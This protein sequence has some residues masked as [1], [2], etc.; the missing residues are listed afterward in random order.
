MESRRN[1]PQ[2]S[3]RHDD[4]PQISHSYDDAFSTPDSNTLRLLVQQIYIS[5]NTEWCI[6]H[7]Y[8]VLQCWLLAYVLLRSGVE[9]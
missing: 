5:Y 1:G 3:S 9:Q 2:L 4:E 8:S 6:C 7:E